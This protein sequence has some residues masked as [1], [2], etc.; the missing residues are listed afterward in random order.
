MTAFFYPPITSSCYDFLHARTWKA[1]HS[2]I[3]LLQDR[4][5]KSTHAEKP[6][7]QSWF[8]SVLSQDLQSSASKLW[9]PRMRLTCG[10]SKKI[11]FFCSPIYLLLRTS[12]CQDIVSSRLS[13]GFCCRIE[14]ANPPCGER[15]TCSLPHPENW[16]Q[17]NLITQVTRA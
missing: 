1:P 11:A 15:R 3:A 10:V 13:R 6:P 2:D 16:L 4:I 9:L 5:S 12:T 7:T 14:L 17:R 8:Q